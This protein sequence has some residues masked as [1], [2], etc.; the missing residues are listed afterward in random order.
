VAAAL[1]EAG[2]GIRDFEVLDFIESMLAYRAEDRPSAKE[3][4]ARCRNLRRRVEGPWLSDWAAE[5]VP[6]ARRTV[7]GDRAEADTLI[8]RTLETGGK[9]AEPTFT[10]T[11]DPAPEPT[12]APGRR[13][14]IAV[15]ALLAALLLGVT[16]AAAGVAGVALWL[17]RATPTTVEPI[18]VVPIEP[19]LTEPPPEAVTEA[20]VPSTPPTIDP[21]RPAPE[22]SNEK[23]PV[24]P[25]NPQTGPSKAPAPA[26]NV[27]VSGAA[28]D[29]VLVGSGRRHRVPGHVPAGAYRIEATFGD[30]PAVEAGAVDVPDAG[31]LQIECLADFQICR[32]R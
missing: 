17:S 24:V 29:V 16:A 2:R 1:D 28:R 19:T 20:V 18:A 6:T 5:A 12:R 15:A 25:S 32:R 10:M 21:V 31:V 7:R 22:A 11:T 9:H 3:V 14:G 23:A 27:R 30:G 8:G 4:E 26:P 13:P